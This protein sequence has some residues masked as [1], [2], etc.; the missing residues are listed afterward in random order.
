MNIEL[1]N[2]CQIG[3]GVIQVPTSQDLYQTYRSFVE[4]F[5]GAEIP[6]RK[7]IS[8]FAETSSSKNAAPIA[9]GRQMNM[10]ENMLRLINNFSK[11][12]FPTHIEYH[13]LKLSS[14]IG[15]VWSD[16]AIFMSHSKQI[17]PLNRVYLFHSTTEIDVSIQTIVASGTR[18]VETNAQDCI[19]A[20]HIPILSSHEL[21][22]HIR[23]SGFQE[24]AHTITYKLTDF[25]DESFVR[26]LTD[27][28]YPKGKKPIE[29]S[30]DEFPNYQN[31]AFWVEL[32]CK[33]RKELNF[34]ASDTRG[35]TAIMREY[36]NPRTLKEFE[37]NVLTGDTK[38]E[39]I[40]ELAD[41]RMVSHELA[42]KI[43]NFFEPKIS[44]RLL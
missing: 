27:F 7:V 33:M 42:V 3:N 21:W 8:L 9:F 31:P 10:Q 26:V 44:R 37:E 32:I 16:T 38:T 11:L 15:E 41:I 35:W 5:E 17:K 43:V 30:V 12:V 14:G 36:R 22:D 39:V 6:V 29:A 40:H 20:H 19:F 4:L 1:I 24:E 23:I 28:I 18:S 25:S 2:K 34:Q 13:D